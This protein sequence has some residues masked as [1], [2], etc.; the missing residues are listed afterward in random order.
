MNISPLAVLEKVKAQLNKRGSNTIRSL[1]REF[2]IMQ[3]G[4]AYGNR[5]ISKQ[6]FSVGL[7]Q[8][9]VVLS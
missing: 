3:A 5:A 1:S 9:G 8:M 6:D 7:K 4:S 2:G